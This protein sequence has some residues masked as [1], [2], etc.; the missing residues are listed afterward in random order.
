MGWAMIAHDA[1]WYAFAALALLSS[2]L[3][4]AAGFH[5]LVSAARLFP[6][7]KPGERLATAL[8]F[9]PVAGAWTFGVA[10]RLVPSMPAAF[11]LAT[12]LGLWFAAA[13]AGRHTFRADIAQHRAILAR[14][15][16]SWASRKVTIILFLAATV[17]LI[18]ILWVNAWVPPYANDPLEY[19]TVA[20]LIASKLALTG[21]YPAIDASVTSGFY[22]PWTHPAGF[23]LLMSWVQ[24]L[25]GD[26]FAAGAVKFIN[27]YFL[28]AGAWVV[29]VYAGGSRRFRGAS[30]A[31]L[32]ALTPLLLSETFEHHVDVVRVALWTGAF[33]AVTCWARLPSLRS[34]LLLGLLFGLGNFVHSIG[35][36]ALPIFAVLA[37]IVGQGPL[38]NR[39]INILATIAAALSIIAP[40]LV[41]NFRSYGRLIGDNVELWDFAPLK[42]YE[43]L[44]YAR[45]ISTPFEIL[46]QGVLS[47]FAWF[48]MFGVAPWLMLAVCLAFAIVRW[49]VRHKSIAQLARRAM[50]P[51]VFSV[52]AFTWLGFFGVTVLSVLAGSELIIKNARYALTTIAFSCILAVDA[53]DL[54]FRICK[55]RVRRTKRADAIGVLAEG[56]LDRPKAA[57]NPQW[58]NRMRWLGA[59]PLG[60]LPATAVTLLALTFIIAVSLQSKGKLRFANI[61]PQTAGQTDQ[62]K[63]GL[64]NH[65]QFRMIAR[66]NRKLSD[67]TWKPSGKVLSFR[68]GDFAYYA[69]FDFLSYIHPAVLPAFKASSAREAGEVLARLGVSYVAVP[70]YSLPEIYN[71]ALGAL[72]A[73]PAAVRILDSDDGYTLYELLKGP[74]TPVTETVGGELKLSEGEPRN[75]GRPQPSDSE[76]EQPGGNDN[77]SDISSFGLWSAAERALFVG[78]PQI[79]KNGEHVFSA[80]MSGSGFARIELIRR[81][82]AASVLWEGLIP[83]KKR[84]ISSHFDLAQL[85]DRES[86][87]S[88]GPENDYEISI[89]MKPGSILRMDEG[90]LQRVAGRESA[91]VIRVNLL[92]LLLLSG[93]DFSLP[94]LPV[95]KLELKAT[96]NGFAAM[97]LDGRRLSVIFPRLTLPDSDL[98]AQLYPVGR[99]MAEVTLGGTGLREVSMDVQCNMFNAQS[100]AELT[101]RQVFLKRY[102]MT[103]PDRVYEFEADTECKIK[104]ARMK[105]DMWRTALNLGAKLPPL[106]YRFGSNRMSYGY[107][108]S[109]SVLQTRE[110]L[111]LAERK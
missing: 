6:A 26:D 80:R 99:L 92:S 108:D 71:S 44:R 54:L 110:L 61:D 103:D 39:I 82:A 27:V 78:A 45:G 89:W 47:Q 109:Q 76:A 69:Q 65:P 88:I 8:L 21:V 62:V 53:G 93:Y 94:G 50:R 77:A 70:P 64:T 29:F 95:S 60:R 102:L 68:V 12:C 73:D 75:P 74:E 111:P 16:R 101:G 86:Q 23:V 59:D 100:A 30:A 28:A 66:L 84:L 43:H 51:T 34:S 104:S 72:L 9:G 105:A 52:S 85:N 58:R 91:E 83:E 40:D 38:W 41:T 5:L 106:A 19:M 2:N 90:K 18:Q 42:V 7:D 17:G 96:G 56:P 14:Q 33:L 87:S 1:F 48:S 3:V 57:P 4:F 98:A 49:P 63:S 25:Q 20:R 79:T 11:Y 10:L 67:G 32:Y 13:F 24:I 81:G 37:L 97:N 31:L 15:G 46:T 107:S 55:G 35:L 36:I 22:G